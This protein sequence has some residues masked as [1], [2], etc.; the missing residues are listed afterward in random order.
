MNLSQIISKFIALVLKHP[1][2]HLLL[3]DIRNELKL[4]EAGINEVLDPFI[5][6]ELI[7]RQENQI[8]CLIEN[9]LRLLPV[10]LTYHADYEDLALYL[11]WREFEAFCKQIVEHHQF[12]CFLNFRFTVPT[13][14]KRYEIDILALRPPY[15]L[16]F[17]AKH[18]QIRAGSNSA[19]KRAIDQQYQRLFALSQVLPSKLLE[20]GINTWEHVNIYPLIVSLYDEKLAIQSK[21]AILP[22]F[23][24]N[25]FLID[26]TEF[27]EELPYISRSLPVQDTLK[28]F[29]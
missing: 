15:I 24:L 22:V 7:T 25:Q 14:K 20:L 27:N 6:E 8:T 28:K 19:L 23:K 1:T 5:S 11:T 16:G 9:R 21:G 17:D 4:D 18:W 26:F 13:N 29:Y 12:Q 2:T 10:G 3:D